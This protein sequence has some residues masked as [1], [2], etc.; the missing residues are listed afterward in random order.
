MI[1]PARYIREQILRM[2]QTELATERGV[3]QP[4]ISKWEKDGSCIPEEHRQAIK[5]LAA[6]RG[7]VVEDIDFEKLPLRRRRPKK[8]QPHA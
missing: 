5:D 8:V 6:E 4:M 1:T 2:T 7:A 3:S